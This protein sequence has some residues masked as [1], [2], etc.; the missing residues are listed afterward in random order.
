MVISTP[1]SSLVVILKAVLLQFLLAEY[2]FVVCC[3]C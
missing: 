1:T 2:D 3:L